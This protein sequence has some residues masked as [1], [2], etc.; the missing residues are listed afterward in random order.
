VQTL[1]QLLP[2]AEIGT[3]QQELPVA[4][5]QELVY[6]LVAVEEY[7]NEYVDSVFVTEKQALLHKAVLE[8]E[9]QLSIA[10]WLEQ[11][12][13]CSCNEEGCTYEQDAQKYSWFVRAAKLIR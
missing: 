11:T 1:P 5:E 10:K 3:A 2:S 9:Q 12:G 13:G 8:A 6:C 4:Q 7:G